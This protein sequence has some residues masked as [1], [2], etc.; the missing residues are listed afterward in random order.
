MKNSD[1]PIKIQIM[2][3]AMNIAR[4]G[5]WVADSY[6]EKQP[7]INKFIAETDQFLSDLPMHH[8]SKQ[9][10]LTYQQFNKEFADLKKEKITK[11]N[12][13]I[14]AEKA[15]TWANILQHRAKVA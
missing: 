7:L 13:L 9:F 4:V 3:I 11:A 14:W 6:Q 10:R 1:F 8:L 2:N 5:N 15:L 12:H